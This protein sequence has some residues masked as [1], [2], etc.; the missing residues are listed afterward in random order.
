MAFEP[1]LRRRCDEARACVIVPVYNNATTVGKVVTGALE[2]ASTVL[3]YDDGSTDGSRTA[4]LDAGA[5]V[6]SHAKNQGKGSVLRL[7][8][9]EA[10]RRQFRYAIA[11][12]ADGQHLASDLP[13]LTT[14]VLDEPGAL[15]IGVRDLRAAGA[16]ASSEFGRR[17]SNWWIWLETGVR[18]PDSQSGFRAYPVEEVC[19]LG[20]R[21]QR[22]EFEADVLLRAAWAGI[23]LRSRPITVVYPAHR[24]S[25]FRL[26]LDNL[27]I[28]AVN[29]VAVLRQPLPLPLG[30]SIFRIPR[31]PGRSLF[32]LRRWAW[33]G[34]SGPFWRGLAAVA[35]VLA[36]GSFAGPWTRTLFWLTPALLGIGAFP[37]IVSTLGYRW[38]TAK[39]LSPMLAAALVVSALVVVGLGELLRPTLRATP[40]QWTGQSRGGVF[41]FW[42][43]MTLTRAFGRSLAYWVVYPVTLYFLLASPSARTASRE[44]LSRAVG[45]TDWL[46]SM[47]RSYRHLLAFARTMVDRALFRTRG[48]RQF[49]YSEEG[50][51]HI[52]D[53]AAAGK[54]AILLTAHVGN[55]ELAAGLLTGSLGERIAV[56]AYEGEWERIARFLRRSEGPH[57]RIIDVSHDVLASVDMVRALREGTLL[58][59]QGDRP[60]G[61]R[62]VAVPFL[63][64]EAP[65]P[66]G[67]FLLAAITGAPVIAT[68]SLKV[69]PGAYRFFAQEPLRLGFTAGQSRDTQLHGWIER[70]VKQLEALVRE[71][72]YQWFNFYDFWDAAPTTRLRSPLASGEAA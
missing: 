40:R 4:A 38:L 20:V 64:R 43:F 44:F 23:P 7:L 70:Y 42:F 46:H 16:P 56:V 32:E 36:A 19:E 18:L 48:R 72:P 60:M 71:Y 27:R 3:V 55:W 61:G 54:G 31:R 29:A 28:I 30:R 69:G 51:H 10:H 5:V 26:V 65:F 2:H 47:V 37:T 13:I 68:F 58:A 11:I 17:C 1:K 57:P 14:A 22:Y 21:H 9:A 53:A 49:R 52:H 33:L 8:I 34:G 39:G 67:P 66:V 25:H 35:G 12:D 6:L 59:V 15:V 50:L 24:T 62:V 63:G 41:G 45:P